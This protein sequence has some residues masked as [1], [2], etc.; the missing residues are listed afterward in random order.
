VL[1]A[2]DPKGFSMTDTSAI[3]EEVARLSAIV[4]EHRRLI[5]ESP[6]SLYAAHADALMSLASRWAELADPAKALAAAEEGVAHFRAL[7]AADSGIFGVH[8]ASALNNLSNRLSESDRETDA[9]TTGGE[10]VTQARGALEKRPDQAR[11]VLISALL[12]QAGRAWKNGTV[13]AALEQMREAAEAFRDGGEAMAPYLGVMVEALHK[14]ALALAEMGLWHQAID[15]RRLV[16][17]CFPPPVPPPVRHLLGLTLDQGATA[18]RAVGKLA[19]ALPFAEE[20]MA[21]GRSLVEADA[22]RYTLFL[23]QMQAN[24]AALRHQSGELG[25][26]MEM[27]LE[28]INNFQ[29]AARTNAA[30]TVAPLAATLGIF[31]EV[32]TTLGHAEQAATVLAQRDGLLEV[33]EKAQAAA[34]GAPA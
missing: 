5:A 4:D 28:A 33:M 6:G 2:L 9:V 11:F 23:A 15:V 14:N 10:A 17:T 22:D 3:D 34:G 27:V 25:E 20:A 26:A 1:N 12:N 13:S 16:A 19:E 32:L 29:Q 31:A 7:A 21:I 8:L 18:M 30:A 24:L